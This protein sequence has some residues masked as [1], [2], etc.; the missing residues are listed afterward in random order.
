MIWHLH[1]LRNDC[2][3]KSS[4]HLSPYQIIKMLLTIFLMLHITSLWHIYHISGVCTLNLLHL[5]CLLTPLHSG[6]VL[7]VLLYLW[8]C[9]HFVLFVCFFKIPHI[10]EILS[11]LSFSVWFILLSIIPSR[12]NHVVQRGKILPFF[13]MAELHSITHGHTQTH[14]PYLLYPFVP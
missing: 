1:T 9:V 14:T 6:N 8:D 5:F 10:S 2:Q 12:S 13:F 3:D 11:H 4:N 7:L